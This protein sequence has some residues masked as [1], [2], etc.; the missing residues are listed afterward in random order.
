[1]SDTQEQVQSRLMVRAMKEHLDDPHHGL[2]GPRLR[3]HVATH[4]VVE[5]QIAE[6]APPETSMTL[7]RL[8]AEGLS[9][10]DA[11]H[12]IGTVVSEQLI[13][14]VGQGGYN[15]QLFRERLAALR[16]EDFSQEP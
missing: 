4:A 1:M 7:Q 13:S 15:E 3:V 11:I 12:A 8:M 14:A 10:H 9:R 16:A 2:D 6:G 5:T